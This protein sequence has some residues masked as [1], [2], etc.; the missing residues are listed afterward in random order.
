MKIFFIA[1][2]ISGDILGGELMQ[3][4]KSRHAD[5]AFQGIGGE[6]MQCEGLQSLV[7]MQELSLMGLWEILPKLPRLY[8]IF[9]KTLQA[10]ESFQPDLIITIDAPDFSFRIARAVKK[11]GA[12]NPHTKLVHYV[13]PT[14]WAWRPGR[15]QKIAKFL[16][17]LICLFPFEPPYFEKHGL[18]CCYGGHPIITALDHLRGLSK[19]EQS[20]AQEIEDQTPQNG[21]SGTHHSK[22]I[23]L[24]LGSRAGEIKRHAPVFLH[25][26]KTLQ[27]ESG[28]LHVRIP[29][30]PHLKD[31]VESALHDCGFSYEIL[32]DPEKKWE[33]MRSCDAALAVSGTVG[34]ELSYAG[35]PHV[36]AYRMSAVT[37]FLLKRL[38]KVPFAHLTNIILNR[39][40]IPEFI[41]NEC[42][43]D[44]IAAELQTLLF[45]ISARQAQKQATEELRSALAL[46]ERISPSVRA[47]DFILSLVPR[48]KK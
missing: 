7:P 17:G 46:P 23:G 43:A 27:Q 33:I 9:H 29:T 45:D 5:I 8:R 40:A 48:L 42:N 28:A 30:L 12:I 19:Q 3:A 25:A 2:E 26:I 10:I 14:V 22:K 11:R 39:R 41:Q 38:V 20:A 35:T 16:D 13:A 34:L 31:L 24:F 1:G 4:L 44:F 36:I 21:D 15:A 32:C 18:P 37:F 6:T 47:A